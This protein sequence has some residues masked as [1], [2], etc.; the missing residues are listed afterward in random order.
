MILKSKCNLR[1]NFT[2]IKGLI[3]IIIFIKKDQEFCTFYASWGRFLIGHQQT[4]YILYKYENKTI[5]TTHC[6]FLHQ[7][8]SEQKFISS[9]YT[10]VAKAKFQLQQCKSLSPD[11]WK[12]MK[13][14]FWCCI[15]IWVLWLM[16]HPPSFS[17]FPKTQHYSLV[18]FVDQYFVIMKFWYHM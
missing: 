12:I 18:T 1:E 2:C 11:Q 14:M 8:R 3:K 9:I 5:T 15:C 4:L 7:N 17:F 16:A 13:L 10:N 6:T